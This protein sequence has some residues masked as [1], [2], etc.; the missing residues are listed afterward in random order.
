[1]PVNYVM[2]AVISGIIG[3]V[4][5]GFTGWHIML[6]SRGQTTIECL[7]KTRYLSPLRKSMQQQHI[8]E[9]HGD[10][11]GAPSY[12]QQLRDIHTNAL[13][14]VTRPEE[15]EVRIGSNEFGIPV[16]QTY[17]DRERAR[18]RQRY[19]EYLDEQ[20]SGKLPNAFDLGWRKNLLH[21][22]GEKPLL[23]AFPICTTTGDGWSWE[24][25]PKWLAAR[26]RIRQ[27]RETQREREQAAGWGESSYDGRNPAPT[28]AHSGAGR[29]YLDSPATSMGSRSPSKADRILGRDPTQYADGP[30]ASRQAGMPM[31]NL[32]RSHNELEDDDDYDSSSDKQDAERKKLNGRLAVGWSAQRLA[33]PAS[34]LLGKATSP[35]SV[36]WNKLGGDADD[37]VD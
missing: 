11:N 23:W 33:S 37:G 30:D 21:L 31:Q 14:G 22:F 29:H 34:G 32:R 7:E 10:R 20:D 2:L 13:P 12:E 4:L 19:E 16:K 26:D 9:H 6:A 35:N 25:S 18:A 36:K 17:D 24:P 27:D 1:M 28:P 3:L 15:G 8:T 5:A